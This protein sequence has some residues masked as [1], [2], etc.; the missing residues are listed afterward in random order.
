MA[1]RISGPGTGALLDEDPS[2]IAP[3]STFWSGQRARALAS[4]ASDM[5]TH[6]PTIDTHA[7]SINQSAAVLLGAVIV[8]GFHYGPDSHAELSR[9]D[10][11]SA[12]GLSI[13][14][15]KDPD[16]D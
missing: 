3:R 2:L 6:R 9:R 5:A 10:T 1:Q 4:A 11:I 8:R 15:S 12:R 7:T 13:L 16:N 14:S